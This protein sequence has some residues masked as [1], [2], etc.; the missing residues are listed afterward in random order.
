M[1]DT[2][3]KYVL[4]GVVASVPKTL[5][6]H[7]SDILFRLTKDLHVSLV[8]MWSFCGWPDQCNESWMI[9]GLHGRYAPPHNNHIWRIHPQFENPDFTFAVCLSAN[10]SWRIEI[11]LEN[12]ELRE[13][14]SEVCANSWL[15]Q[16]VARKDHYPMLGA[17]NLANGGVGFQIEPFSVGFEIWGGTFYHY[18]DASI[19][20]VLPPFWRH[21]PYIPY[22]LSFNPSDTVSGL[23]QLQG[24][25]LYHAP[26]ALCP[27]EESCVS[28][29]SDGGVN[30]KT[31]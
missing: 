27:F 15:S 17:T 1:I 3:C 7:S 4:V 5:R 13:K 12:I 23:L 2:K 29:R 10:H 21:C 25:S 18:W 28:H 24:S 26:T 8:S 11:W 20:L 30:V 16:A 31:H 19:C 9:C 14:A 6:S 22:H